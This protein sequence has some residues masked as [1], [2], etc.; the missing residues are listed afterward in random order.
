VVITD[1]DYPDGMPLFTYTTPER[2]ASVCLRHG[3]DGPVPLSVLR[4]RTADE[5]RLARERTDASSDYLE[6]FLKAL[7]DLIARLPLHLAADPSGDN[8]A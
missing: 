4:Q 7:D 5:L 2:L 1:T 6:Q 8:A 3:P